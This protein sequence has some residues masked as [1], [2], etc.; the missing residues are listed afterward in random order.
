[1][2]ISRLTGRSEYYTMIGQFWGNCMSSAYD[3]SIQ[4][5]YCKW[6]GT[7]NGFENIGK[8]TKEELIYLRGVI[9]SRIDNLF[10]PFVEGQNVVQVPYSVHW[11]PTL[12]QPLPNTIYTISRVWFIEKKWYLSFEEFKAESSELVAKYP[13]HLFLLSIR[14]S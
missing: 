9:D 5:L 13:H 6:L 3:D 2:H 8:N 14:N 10:P 1:M 4:E 11:I 12:P 7:T